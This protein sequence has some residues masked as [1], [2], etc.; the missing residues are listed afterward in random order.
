LSGPGE[1]TVAVIGGGPAGAVAARLLTSWGHE[2]VLLARHPSERSLGE[3]LPPSCMRVIDRVGVTG[4]DEKPGFLRATGNT[5]RW[6]SGDERVEMFAT[7]TSGFQVDRAVFDAHLVQH[8]VA[9]GADV[10]FGAAVTGVTHGERSLV[11]YTLEGESH[12]VAACWVMDCTGRSGLVARNGWRVAEPGGRTLALVAVFERDDP[13]PMQDPTHTMVESTEAGWGWSVPVS[14]ARRYVTLMVDPALTGVGG[15]DRLDETYHAQLAQTRSLRALVRGARRVGGAFARDASAYSANRYGDRGT[16]L[17]GDAGSFVDPLSSFGIKKALAS[18]WLGAVVVNSSLHSLTIIDAA[19]DLFNQRER[20]MVEALRRQATNLARDA[21]RAHP[22]DFWTGRAAADAGDEGLE[23]DTAA[24]RSD[25]DVLA[26]LDELRRREA[27]HLRPAP[28]AKRLPRPT[29]RGNRVVIEEHL[30]VP[31]F[32]EGVRY[33]RN[34]DLVR[35][36][37]LAVSH[38]QVPDL[39]AAYNRTA[40]PAPLPDFLGALSVLIGKGMLVFA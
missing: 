3:S 32:P 8:A 40:S 2:V 6:G 21:A 14:A 37:D 27:I 25:P 35:L 19:I 28:A 9:A 36:S 26:S 1:R 24:L 10:R 5:V 7:G 33:V 38:R 17:V 11:H 12:T 13:W 30:V 4:I 29:V 39:F 22:V 16:L 18:A 31:A 34:V 20:I 15:R 23:P